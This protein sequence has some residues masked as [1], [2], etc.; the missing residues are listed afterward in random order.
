MNSA[1]GLTASLAALAFGVVLLLAAPVIS[2]LER[3]AGYP[4]GQMC[5]LDRSCPQ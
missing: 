2:S 4:F 1:L 5:D 3:E